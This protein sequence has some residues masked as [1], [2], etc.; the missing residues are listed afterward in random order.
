MQGRINHI[1]PFPGVKNCVLL[2]FAVC[3]VLLSRGC[4]K[5]LILSEDC[6]MYFFGSNNKTLYGMFCITGDP[7][8][9]PNDAHL[10][11]DAING[12]YKAHRVDRSRGVLIRYMPLL[13]EN[14]RRR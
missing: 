14:C 12:P 7:E 9:V 4:V 1:L 13:I 6:N 2:W 3:G 8:E 10:T 11:Q 5:T